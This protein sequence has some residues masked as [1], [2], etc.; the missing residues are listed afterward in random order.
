MTNQSDLDQRS[1]TLFEHL[2]ELRIRLV[3]IAY[4]LIIGMGLCYSVSEKV[5]DLIR[6]PIQPYLSNG[7]LIY[8]GPLDKFMAH[9]K[10]SFTLGI[11]LMSPFVFYQIWQFIAP[12]LYRKERNYAF[13]FIGAATGLFVT[14]VAFSYFVVLPMAFKF[15]MTF[16][17]DTDKPMIAIDSYLSFFTQMCLVFGAAFELPLI[18]T[19]LGMFGLVSQKFLKE[20]R[21]YAIVILAAI[22]GIITPPDL[23]SM[24]MMLFPMILLYEISVIFVGIFERQRLKQQEELN[25]ESR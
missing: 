18:I 20:K 11:I 3:K 13:G 12:G 22:S 23:M 9:L 16:G 7:G 24:L 10:I 4:S 5:F 25:N 21:R 17:G 19:T 6:R 2:H 1:Q 15:L 8:T 14:G